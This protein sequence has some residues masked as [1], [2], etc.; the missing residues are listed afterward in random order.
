MSRVSGENHEVA[1]PLGFHM[2]ELL[3]LMLKISGMNRELGASRLEF[4]KKNL[5]SIFGLRISQFDEVIFTWE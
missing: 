4:I 5:A 3:P 2:P 1:Q